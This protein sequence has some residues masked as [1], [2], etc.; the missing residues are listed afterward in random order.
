MGGIK[1][2]TLH[3]CLDHSPSVLRVINTPE[4]VHWLTE[5]RKGGRTEKTEQTNAPRV[6]ECNEKATHF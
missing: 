3:L 2:I 4:N 5:G 1:E 6:R